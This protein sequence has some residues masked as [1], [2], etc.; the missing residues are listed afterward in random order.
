MT[1]LPESWAPFRI[2]SNKVCTQYPEKDKNCIL[3]S[4]FVAFRDSEFVIA[5]N[6]WMAVALSRF[7][8]YARCVVWGG[9]TDYLGKKS[10]SVSSDIKSGFLLRRSSM[11][12]LS[13]VP[14]ICGLLLRRKVSQSSRA[15]MLSRGKRQFL[16]GKL[17]PWPWKFA[18]DHQL[19]RSPHQNPQRHVKTH[20]FDAG[21][22]S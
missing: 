10:F 16:S 18:I 15:W 9:V 8:S 2:W 17:L 3:L 5:R 12:M 13:I 14:T 22:S 6:Y 4:L 1:P 20:N 7:E 19:R 21:R 11:R